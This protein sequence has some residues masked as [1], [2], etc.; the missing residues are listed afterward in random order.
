[1]G[2]NTTSTETSSDTL[3]F[4]GLLLDVLGFTDTEFAGLGYA[5]GSDS[6]HTTVLP[7]TDAPE[8]AATIPATANAYFGVNPVAGPP[9]NNK[10]RGRAADVIRLAT[11]WAD[12]DVKAGACDDLDV[13]RIIIDDL[14]VI[15]GTRP[16]AIVNSGHGLHPYW[17]ISDGRIGGADRAKMWALLKRWGRLVAVVAA[18]RGVKV[19]SVF[20]LARMLRIPGSFN[21]K[22]AGNGAGP[23]RVTGRRDVGAPL[24]L[25]E[26]D[27]RLTEVGIPEENEDKRGP[28]QAR[29]VVSDPADWTF[30]ENTC[31]YLSVFIDGLLSDGPKRGGGRHQWLLKQAVRLACARRMGCLAEAGYR[32][33]G[34]LLAQR[35]TQLRAA[36]GEQVG[37][38]EIANAL[39]FG[40]EVTA[41][42]TEEQA[43]AE[44][45]GHRHEDVTEAFSMSAGDDDLVFW[46]QT[47]VLA[48]IHAFARSRGASP[49][50]VLGTVL[51]RAIGCVEPYVVLPATV[52]G[53]VSLNLFTAPVGASGA[54]KDTANEVGRDAV[55]FG[56]R[57]GNAFLGQPDAALI[58]PG[59]GEGLARGFAGRGSTP[60]ETRAHLQV[61]DV[62]TLEALAG[63]KGQTLVGQLLAAYMGQP[64]G[65]TNN[66][67]D[68]T[69][70][71][72]AHEYRLC[73]SVGVQPENA[74]F[75]LSRDSH[76]FPQRF[77]WLPT[78]DPGAPRNRPQP[79]DPLE[80]DLPDF[81]LEEKAERFEM[82][83]PP[84]VVDE[85]WLHR[86]RVLTG[87]EG[88]DPLDG[89]LKL[90]QLKVAAAVAILHGHNRVIDEAWRIAGRL[91]EVSTKVRT[92]LRAEVEARR[93]REN[94]AKARDQAD[95]QATVEVLLADSHQRRVRNA[96]ERKLK[97]VNEAAEYELEKACDSSIRDD[98]KF[99]FDLCLEEGFIVCCDKGGD[100]RAARYCLG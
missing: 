39:T 70:A 3:D 34:K 55:R 6:F 50:A 84:A 30:A 35:L 31:K 48:H 66:A 64:L 8:V 24:T 91:I 42:K 7:P 68:T 78:T 36:T 26:V 59:T 49:Y 45:G 100:G 71:V 28:E 96:I 73:L 40:V 13:V 20:D 92:G 18:K 62:G 33:A 95:R 16:S 99:V 94:T 51:R 80:V 65:F 4:T 60:G 98:F 5:V 52:G 82:P 57:A 9:R 2:N 47:E 11:L 75:F 86:W 58:H 77:M 56:H 19:D 27:E 25:A 1:M 38:F 87:V 53:Q 10:G 37:R 90:T 63:R 76:G 12:L 41:G 44:L 69:T 21:N 88:V 14:S 72:G 43:R 83:I 29:E 23:L 89:H 97:R 93:R 17:P 15:L 74:G 79:I 54:G 32:R 61:P 81:R 22:F 46:S 85:I 67:K